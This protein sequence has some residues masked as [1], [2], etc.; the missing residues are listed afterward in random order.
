MSVGGRLARIVR[1][2]RDHTTLRL[3]RT[4]SIKAHL[5]SL[6]KN[7]GKPWASAP[8]ARATPSMRSA[9]S[10]HDEKAICQQGSG[11]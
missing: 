4:L 10:Q 9:P 2:G 1:Q 5:V 8:T 7:G 6:R 3:S 11:D